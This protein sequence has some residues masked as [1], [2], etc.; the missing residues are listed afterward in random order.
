MIQGH[1][2]LAGSLFKD[3]GFHINHRLLVKWTLQFYGGGE[4]IW[5]L[6]Q[7]HTSLKAGK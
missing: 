2:A 5:M 3:Y 4:V 7:K 1:S 6:S